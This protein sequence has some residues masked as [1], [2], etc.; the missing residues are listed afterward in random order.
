MSQTLSQIKPNDVRNVLTTYIERHFALWHEATDSGCIRGKL[1]L[2][3]ARLN[4]PPRLFQQYRLTPPRRQ[5]SPRASSIR[6]FG[7][8]TIALIS[9]LRLVPVNDYISIVCGRF[10]RKYTWREIYELYRLTVPAAIPNLPPRYNICPTTTIDAVLSK[11]GKREL[12][13]MRWGLVPGWWNKPLKEL[14]LSTF[15]AR[16]E[17]VANK[18]FFR[19]AF[20]QS[21]CLIPASGDYEWQDTPMGKQPYYF[22]RRDGSVMSIAGLWDEWKNVETGEPLKSCTMII[23]D[24]NV[25]V[26]EV[27]DR[28]PV[29]LE[30]GDFVAWLSGD[31]GVEILKPAAN[32]VLQRWPVSKRVNS[33]R[34]SDDDETLIA[35]NKLQTTA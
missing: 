21:R 17:T 9:E 33:S 6:A 28:M 13:P 30:P 3:G 31:A 2:A 5:I 1:T 26:G 19:S 18:P 12:V 10:T 35:E 32:D 20:K 23:S 11:D 15:N 25:F 14:K 29:L 24:A 16:V 34:A 27:H 8:A 22:A 7:L 4:H